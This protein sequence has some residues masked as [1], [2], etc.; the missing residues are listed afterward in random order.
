M[1]DYAEIRETTIPDAVH[2]NARLL[3]VE[4]ARRTQPFGNKS[5]EEKI[6]EKAISTDIYGGKRSSGKGKGR[7]GLFAHITPRQEAY[8]ENFS[9]SDY[10]TVHATKDGTVYGIDRAH[11]LP[12]AGV[13][14]I[15]SIHRANFVN[16]RMSAAGG[17]THNIG[18]WKFINKYFVPKSE[19]AAFV[20][21]RFARVGLAKSGWATCANKL[22]K[23][24]SG[25]MTREIPGWVTRHLGDYGL[26][27]VRDNTSNT[28]APT[29]FLTNTCK[30][31]DKVLRET[32]KLQGLSIVAGKMKKQMERIL[33]HRQ[34]KLQEAA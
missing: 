22:K 19:L 26:G 18:R 16:G 29:V 5:G 34:T 11:F 2:M 27:E 6:G 17:D 9:T 25:S 33:K 10:I 31:A 15:A 4:F 13:S 23:V 3:C 24:V 21:T 12:G 8:A 20:A 14:D 28:S 32:E 7:A 30:Y 1:K